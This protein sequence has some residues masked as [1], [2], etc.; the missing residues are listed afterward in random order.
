MKL[1]AWVG[2]SLLLAILGAA[3]ARAET[4]DAEAGCGS[5]DRRAAVL[6]VDG[7]L[8]ERPVRV[9]VDTG[10]TGGISSALAKGRTPIP[11]KKARFAGASGKFIDS[12]LYEI[13][14]LRIGGVTVP[15]FTA[16]V[17]AELGKGAIPGG[18]DVMIGVGELSS[19]VVDADLAAHQLCLRA[20]L[21]ADAPPLRAFE[22]RDNTILVPAALGPRRFEHFIL[23]TGAGVS[24]LSERW[25][26]EVPHHPR[27]ERVISVDA[28]GVRR[29][30]RYVDVDR[31]CLFDYCRSRQVVMP[32]DDLS[33]LNGFPVQGIIGMT[34]LKGYRLLIDLPHHRLALIAR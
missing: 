10:G 27:S 8:G 33:A 26:G 28:S 11:G 34:F 1:A 21:P 7:L 15:R 17:L 3:S 32:D 22:E 13:A 25:L 23:D 12:D 29:E 4:H 5:V 19:F 6:V 14:E 30:Q 2:V 16:T 24:T 9:F 18:Y 31:V 20:S